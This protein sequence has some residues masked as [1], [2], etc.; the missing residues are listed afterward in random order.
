MP[1]LDQLTILAP[2]LLGG[3]VARAA[4]ARGV[5]RRIVLWAPTWR[6]DRNAMVDHL[7]PAELADLLG[8]EWLVLVRGHAST[9]EH[10]SDITGDGVLD[11]T[12]Y[13]DISDLLLVADLLVTDYSSVMFD[14]LVTGKPIV[15]CVPDLDRYASE[16]RGFYADLLAEAPGPVV[17]TTSQV[18]YEIHHAETD[19]TRYEPVL[20]A[21]RERF[22]YRDDGHTAEHVLNHM[23]EFGWFGSDGP[24]R[25]MPA[26][27]EAPATTAKHAKQESGA[28]AEV[29]RL[30]HDRE[31]V[32]R[33]AG[34]RRLQQMEGPVVQVDLALLGELGQLVARR[35]L[36]LVAVGAQEVLVDDHLVRC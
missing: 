13:P 14:W 34:V 21:W 22:A 30:E 5:A 28:P 17:Q 18:A 26:A 32:Q 15:Y 3:S 23:L 12:T 20:A 6:E 11:V 8:P 16:L 9:W 1:A 35:E 4:R 24:E 36:E 25:L 29:H 7:D 33:L 10:G 2:G 27:V 31:G 19:A